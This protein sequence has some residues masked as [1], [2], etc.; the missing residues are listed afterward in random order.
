VNKEVVQCLAYCPCL[1]QITLRDLTMFQPSGMGDYLDRRFLFVICDF[2]VGS[3][4]CLA[5]DSLKTW[6]I[7]LTPATSTNM[8]VD[9]Y[10]NTCTM[11]LLLICTMTNTC[12]I[13]SQIFTFLHVLT[14]L[15]HPQGACNQYLAKLHKYFKCSCW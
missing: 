10:F 12:A 14:L 6:R 9:D 7:G 4:V 11:H 2:N 8:Y 5:W 15:Y 3:D 13:I 1:L